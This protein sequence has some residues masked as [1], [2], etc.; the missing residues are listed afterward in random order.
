MTQLPDDLN[1]EVVKA[2]AEFISQITG[3]AP[4]PHDAFPPEWYGYM[5][6]FTSR[7]YEI[8]GEN[9]ARSADG[10]AIDKAMVKRLAIQHGLIPATPEL[11]T[12][13]RE[14]LED[15]V[16][17]YYDFQ[18][19]LEYRRETETSADD[20]SYWQHQLDVLD[21]MREQARRALLRP[22]N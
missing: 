16:S 22:A 21:R 17:H 8:A 15:V 10:R 2:T 3:L 9:A 20:K 6:A 12:D 14:C 18:N 13:A 5:R 4:P 19:A 1:P 11:S 7:L